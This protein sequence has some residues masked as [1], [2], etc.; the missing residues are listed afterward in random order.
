MEVCFQLCGGLRLFPGYD[1]C[2]KSRKF[3]FL[4]IC[5]KDVVPRG[6]LCECP[7]AYSGPR[8][9]LTT[10]TFQGNSYIWLPPKTPHK[11]GSISLE[12]ATSAAN[13]LLFYQGP[14][15]KGNFQITL[16][17]GDNKF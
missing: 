8:C 7:G 16:G 1:K 9:Q 15:V 17:S 11:F 5:H 10:R 3:L 6:F 13:G 14:A 2:F 4:G 12:F